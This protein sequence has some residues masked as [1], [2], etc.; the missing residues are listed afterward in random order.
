MKRFFENFIRYAIII[1][2][3]SILLFSFFYTLF[4]GDF[5]W[6]GFLSGSGGFRNY[7]N[8]QYYDYNE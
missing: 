2:I 7:A 4:S 5:D 8:Q 3:I 6:W 1:Y